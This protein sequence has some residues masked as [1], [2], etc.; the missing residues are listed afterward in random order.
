MRVPTNF[1]FIK[2]AT[3]SCRCV[4]KNPLQIL[5]RIHTESIIN[6]LTWLRITEH[7]DSTSKML[8]SLAVTATHMN[9]DQTQ[10]GTLPQGSFLWN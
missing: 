10:E 1:R 9:K 5:G 3:I 8:H 7:I 4:Y 6:H 2:V